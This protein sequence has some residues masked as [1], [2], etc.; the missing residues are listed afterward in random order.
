MEF[1][2]HGRWRDGN[3]SRIVSEKEKCEGRAPLPSQLPLDAIQCWENNCH[4]W[5]V[6]PRNRK[7]NI[8]LFDKSIC[9]SF[10]F[11]FFMLNTFNSQCRLRLQRHTAAADLTWLTQ[12]ST[13]TSSHWKTQHCG[14]LDIFLLLLF[15]FFL[16]QNTFIVTDETLCQKKKLQSDT[17]LARGETKSCTILCCLG[18]FI[19]N[20][21]IQRPVCTLN[22]VTRILC[23]FSSAFSLWFT[24]WGIWCGRPVLRLYLATTLLL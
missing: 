4:E 14:F 12:M 13:A 18:R 3:L 5:K 9:F 8:F 10:S 16:L 20:L 19:F 24:V 15:F 21:F 11:L 17:F 2:V 6:R 23:W 7:K 1:N 22:V